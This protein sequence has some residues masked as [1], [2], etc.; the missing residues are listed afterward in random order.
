MRGILIALLVLGS[1][2]VVAPAEA[3]VA[4]CEWG[5]VYCWA[6][7]EVT[8]VKYYFTQYHDCYWTTGPYPIP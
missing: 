2:A 8:H 6:K 5:D 3:H 4:G 7:C 1:L